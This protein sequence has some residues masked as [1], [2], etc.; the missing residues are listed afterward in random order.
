MNIY[1]T[2]PVRRCDNTNVHPRQRSQSKQKCYHPEKSGK[3]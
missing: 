2:A 1:F 3:K